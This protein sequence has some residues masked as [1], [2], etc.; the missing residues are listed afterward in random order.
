MTVAAA[1]ARGWVVGVATLVLW[2]LPG[3]ARAEGRPAGL[4]AVISADASGPDAGAIKTALEHE[5]GVP[6]VIA[7]GAEERLEVAVSGRRA[8]VTYFGRGRDP[9]TR[10]VD[11]PKDPER[12]LQTVA[13]LGGNLARDEASE[14]LRDLTPPADETPPPA[15]PAPEAKPP[16]PAPSSK[17]PEAEKPAA[18][19][20]KLLESNRF[21]ANVSL[22][23]PATARP[24]TE[25]WRLNLE[26]GVA[27]SR[28]GAIN[29]VGASLGY[30]R[31][32]QKLQGLGAGLFWIRTGE[33]QGIA[34]SFV[35]A[36]GYGRLKGIGFA[37][38][39]NWR[40]GNVDGLQAS[41]LVTTAHDVLGIE[42]A[43]L[44]AVGRD[45]Q[46]FQGSVGASVARDLQGMQLGTVGVA[47]DVRGVQTGIVNVGR[48]VQGLQLGIVNVGQR[49]R[50]L[51]VGLVNVAEDL[52]GGAI[53]LVNYARNG[54]FQPVAWMVGPN[55]TPLAG[56]KS[57]TGL[58]YMQGGIG[59]ELARDNYR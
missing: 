6:L 40:V 5:L 59:Y 7:P 18:P 35:A 49:V 12:A 13:F 48:D 57:I 19:P 29:G 30:L 15:P 41:A 43:A 11:L 51:Q 56:Y 53:G 58:T 16:V 17:P 46:G 28:V 37:M 54:R 22:F 39:A 55:L 36:E 21:A 24:H 32:D 1:F 38:L 8:N 34:A 9:V 20:E 23:Y 52:D 33:V 26:L 45:V 42:G 10:S 27:Y 44:V 47:R 14:L 2:L 50:G 25:K 4:P 31:I 3:H